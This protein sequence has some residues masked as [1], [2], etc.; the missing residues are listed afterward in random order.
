MAGHKSINLAAP[1]LLSQTLLQLGVAMW[2]FLAT[3]SIA[4]ISK[5]F[6]YTRVHFILLKNWV[7][8]EGGLLLGRESIRA[9]GPTV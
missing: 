1:V 2:S 5:R 6:N 3:G 9:S 4:F 7:D 8:L